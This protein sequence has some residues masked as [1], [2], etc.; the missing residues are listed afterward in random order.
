MTPTPRHQNQPIARGTHSGVPSF[1]LWLLVL[2]T[3][4]GLAFADFPLTA[5]GG[6]RSS[7]L[8]NPGIA[9]A[10]I[11]LSSATFGELLATR[12][13]LIL[14]A[15]SM[16]PAIAIAALPAQVPLLTSLLEYVSLLLWL[17][18]LHVASTLPRSKS[19]RLIL[20]ALVLAII[21]LAPI[22]WYFS[23][24]FHPDPTVARALVL[25]S[26]ILLIATG[27]TTVFLPFTA[28]ALALSLILSRLFTSIRRTP[29]RP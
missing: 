21:C 17:W 7:L 2:A 20:T 28:I 5:K 13:R 1:I 9:I 11:L 12:R 18:S 16:F 6:Y 24:E 10:V 26:P 22:L 8:G 23:R 14:A 29:S 3:L 4:A 19:Q 25:S 15:A 27:Q